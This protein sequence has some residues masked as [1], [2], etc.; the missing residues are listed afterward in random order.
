M[1]TLGYRWTRPEP[2]LDIG[3]DHTVGV[4]CSNFDGGGGVDWESVL[5][6]RLPDCSIL[7]EYHL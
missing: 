3:I 1:H 2:H 4:K 6:I 7:D 5:R